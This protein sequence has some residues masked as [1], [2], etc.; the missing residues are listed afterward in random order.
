MTPPSDGSRDAAAAASLPL[1][2][3]EIARASTLPSGFYHDPAIHARLTERVLAPSR[4]LR[5]TPMM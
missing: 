4:S 5:E 2:H 3:P 1:V